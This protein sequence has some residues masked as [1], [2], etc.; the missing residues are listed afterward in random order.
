M[1]N[2]GVDAVVTIGT[3][4][5]I[6]CVVTQTGTDGEAVLVATWNGLVGATVEVAALD[7]QDD[8][9]VVRLAGGATVAA[10]PQ[11]TM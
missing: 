7:L 5:V 9:R 1:W 8:R 6:G 10:T 2:A 4:G 11:T 3:P